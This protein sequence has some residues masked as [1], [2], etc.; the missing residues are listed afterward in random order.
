MV[1]NHSMIGFA[2]DWLIES[3]ELVLACAEEED[4]EGSMEVADMGQRGH[5]PEGVM[6]SSGGNQGAAAALRARLNGKPA[7]AVLPEGTACRLCI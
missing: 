6:G 3:D 2:V 5:P 4:I 1:I 7:P